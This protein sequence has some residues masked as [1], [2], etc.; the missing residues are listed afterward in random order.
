MHYDLDASLGVYNLFDTSYAQ[1]GAEEHTMAVIEQD[2][3]SVRLKVTY[4]F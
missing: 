4:R 3:I 2:R 1:P